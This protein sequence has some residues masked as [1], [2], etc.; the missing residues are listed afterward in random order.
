MRGEWELGMKDM[1]ITLGKKTRSVQEVDDEGG[2]L[3]FNGDH[4][5]VGR[6]EVDGWQK[7]I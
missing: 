7:E 2:E 5:V 3:N 6:G 1:I 4:L